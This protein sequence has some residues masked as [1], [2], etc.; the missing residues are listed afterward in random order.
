[1]IC[2]SSSITK[3]RSCIVLYPACLFFVE[4]R[5]ISGAP[6]LNDTASGVVGFTVSAPSG[7]ACDPSSGL[8]GNAKA[9]IIYN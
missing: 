2:D 8:G 4:G 7:P 5:P 6:I 9:A 3:I 1:V